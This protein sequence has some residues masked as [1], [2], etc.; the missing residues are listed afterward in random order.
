MPVLALGAP[1]PP[2]EEPTRGF[3]H[4]RLS[5]GRGCELGFSL[6]QRFV[7]QTL[8]VTE[9]TIRRAQRLLWEEMGIMAEPDGAV[10]LATL[11]DSSYA[12]APGEQ[13]GVVVCGGNTDPAALLT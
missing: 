9:E 1:A 8:L 10:A 11:L 12:P 4:G 6:A 3:P 7:E 5:H 13:V 2:N